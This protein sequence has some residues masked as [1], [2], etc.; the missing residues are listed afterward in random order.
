VLER[1]VDGRGVLRQHYDTEALDASDLLIALVRFLPADDR[2]AG[3][4]RGRDPHRA[5]RSRLRAALQVDQTDDGSW[6]ARARSSPA[7]SGR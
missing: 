2:A 4:D 1:G 5:R 3:R 7:R 6:A